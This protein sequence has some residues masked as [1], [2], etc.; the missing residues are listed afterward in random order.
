[1]YNIHCI[2]YVYGGSVKGFIWSIHP[3]YIFNIL[4]EKRQNVMY[5]HVQITILEKVII[6]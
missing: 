4:N 2:S 3:I 6:L 1:M 5:V